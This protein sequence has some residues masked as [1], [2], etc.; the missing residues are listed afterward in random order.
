MR[1]I[2]QVLFGLGLGVVALGLFLD[3]GLVVTKGSPDLHSLIVVLLLLGASQWI[4]F[5]A[6][7]R[8]I[9]IQVIVGI[10]LFAVLLVVLVYSPFPVFWEEKNLDSSIS[11]TWR[12]D[13][14]LLLFA[15]ATQWISFLV[16][17][18]FRARRERQK[19]TQGP[20]SRRSS[21]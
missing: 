18:Y 10:V 8:R 17:D 20:S 4:A 15:V 1:A 6:F 13:L 11:I 19:Q 16:F 14:V 7:H 21:G 2:W 3:L 5:Y 9:A 12:S